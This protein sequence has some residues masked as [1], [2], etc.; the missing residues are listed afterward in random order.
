[1]S[2]FAAPSG[3]VTLTTDFGRI[4]P[5]AGIMKG[6]ILARHPAA[7][8]VDL[9]HDVPPF[10]PEVGGFWLRRAARWFPA[11]TVH[12]AVVDPGVGTRRD[13]VCVCRD[14]Q[15]FVA[16][17]NGLAEELTRGTDAAAVHQL[18]QPTLERLGALAA[19]AT[20]HGRDIFAPVAAALSAGEI[21]P[22]ELGPAV[23]DLVP[24]RMPRPVHGPEIEGQIVL[25]DRYGNLVTNIA[26]ERLREFRRPVVK[27]PPLAL[28]LSTTYGEVAEGEYLALIN[29][30]ELLE[31]A[32]NGGSAAAGL[33]LG[34]GHRVTVVEGAD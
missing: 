13:I 18:A 29:S 28:A 21:Q 11:G 26:V 14:A 10:R 19:S 6:V 17:D 2:D 4:D 8:V 32:R 23:T 34:E 12:V 9:T 31:I 16:P 27:A 7:R 33:G 22:A 15:A 20:F 5:Y 3:L 1:M 24:S 25:A 30:F